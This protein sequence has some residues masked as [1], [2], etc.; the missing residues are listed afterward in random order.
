MG[1]SKAE[2][3]SGSRISDDLPAI[4]LILIAV[5][6]AA[7]FLEVGFTGADDYRYLIAAERWMNEGVHTGAD[8]WANRLP[9]VFALVAAYSTLGTNELALYVLHGT[10]TAILAFIAWKIAWWAFKD[11]KSAWFG[12]LMFLSTPLLLRQTTYSR[13]EVMEIGALALTSLLVLGRHRWNGTERA[14]VL[15]AAGIIGGVAVLVRQ[16]AVAVPVSLA[17]I[18]LFMTTGESIAIRVRDILLLAAGF[19]LPLIAE[20]AFYVVMTGDPFHRFAVDTS[21]VKI[22]DRLLDKDELDTNRVLFNWE[23]ARNW[24][25][26]ALIGGPWWLT[27]F[28]RLFIGAG[29]LLVAVTGVVGGVISWRAGH[30]ARTLA[31]FAAVLIFVQYILNTLVLVL[32]PN[33]RYFGLGLVLL[34]LFAG[35]AVSRLPHPAAA[36]A[37][38]IIFFTLPA[39][40]VLT[41][42]IRFSRMSQDMT[43]LIRSANDP[44][45]LPQQTVK[46]MALRLRSDPS[47]RARIRIGEAP[48]GALIAQMGYSR[49]SQLAKPC[50]DGSAEVELVATDSPYAPFAPLLKNLSLESLL[51]AGLRRIFTGELNRASLFRRVC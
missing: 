35:Y 43:K 14:I 19:I 28:M 20:T 3:A 17:T 29:M 39:I 41:V 40:L 12:L 26:N 10:L 33:T 48:T 49:A 18:M 5:A 8:H 11:R 15:I 23:I 47:L 44:V 9:Y 24:D 4:A 51:P 32:P 42:D 1:A 7:A 6:C 50:A 25:R 27:P 13:P 21:H 34:A 16:T 36:L 31:V 38:I 45:W 30:A 37:A 2:N 22:A 46:Y